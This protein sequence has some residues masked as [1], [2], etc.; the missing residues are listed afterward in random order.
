M[1]ALIAVL[2]VVGAFG[3]A[4]PATAKTLKPDQLLDLPVVEG[5]A[6]AWDGDTLWLEVTEPADLAGGGIRVRL[7]GIS[8]PEMRDASEGWPSRMALDLALGFEPGAELPT[9]RCAPR[10]KHK[11]RL[12]AVCRTL[13]GADL[14]LAVVAAGLASEYRTF[15]R[16]PRD[17]DQS[18]AATYAAAEREAYDARRGI[19]AST[20]TGWPGFGALLPSTR[21]ETWAAVQAVFSILAI[22]IAAGIPTWHHFH[23]HAKQKRQRFETAQR[24]MRDVAND[25]QRMAN[26]LRNSEGRPDE[27]S[28]ILAANAGNPSE[29]GLQR[30]ESRISTMY[31]PIIEQLRLCTTPDLAKLTLEDHVAKSLQSAREESQRGIKRAQDAK[32]M[33][34]NAIRANGRNQAPVSADEVDERLR[35]AVGHYRSAAGHIDHALRELQL[36]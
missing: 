19:W 20:G 24:A 16:D 14:A 12:V 25:W 4:P 31:T 7:W 21:A 33:V 13:A 30:A 5:R 17:G 18:L 34:R 23:G 28:E 8:A 35:D 10:D 2:A 15:T 3:L 36:T 9:I 1:R 22:A 32:A 29:A 11:S 6:V 26:R 27:V